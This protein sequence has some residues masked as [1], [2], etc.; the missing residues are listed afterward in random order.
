MPKGDRSRCHACLEQIVTR[1]NV[2]ARVWMRVYSNALSRSLVS[3]RAAS[4]V[5]GY[6]TARCFG[7]RP[8]QQLLCEQ[9]LDMLKCN[10]IAC[11]L[12]MSLC[13]R[14]VKCQECDRRDNATFL[15]SH[16]IHSHTFLRTMIRPSSKIWQSRCNI[17]GQSIG[18]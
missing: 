12:I 4:R 9:S 8:S 15:H 16:A 3:E 10:L 18:L 17:I 14:D 13:K 2:A 7:Q 5:R 6:E 11:N 1:R